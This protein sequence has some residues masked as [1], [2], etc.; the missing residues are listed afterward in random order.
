MELTTQHHIK[1]NEKF[2]PIPIALRNFSLQCNIWNNKRL[3]SPTQTNLKP[4]F[5]FVSKILKIQIAI[6]HGKL[7]KKI[8]DPKIGEKS[9]LKAAKQT[10]SLVAERSGMANVLISHINKEFRAKKIKQAR[11]YLS[12]FQHANHW[13]LDSLFICTS[14]SLK[15]NPNCTRMHIVHRFNLWKSKNKKNI[16]NY[17]STNARWI[18]DDR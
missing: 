5:T 16:F 6:L 10:H 18:W 1:H 3:N 13:L 12:F 15:R 14:L 7:K 8:D 2:Y 4:S 9:Q 11:Y 17:Y